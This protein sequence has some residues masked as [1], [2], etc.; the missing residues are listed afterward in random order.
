M[1]RWW[2]WFNTEYVPFKQAQAASQIVPVTPAEKP[3]SP[4]VEKT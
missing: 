3:V 4:P 1:K 2:T